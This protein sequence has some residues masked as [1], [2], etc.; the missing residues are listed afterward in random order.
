M[1]RP[2]PRHTRM[3]RE[4][5]TRIVALSLGISLTVAV[6]AR[7]QTSEDG[8]RILKAM[9]DYVA[10]QDS[11]YAT[12]D[13]DI[14][15]ITPQLQKIQF[16]SSGQLAMSRPDKIRVTR[17]GGY[18]DLELAFDGNTATVLERHTNNYAQ[19]KAPGSVDQLVDK[20]RD[21]LGTAVP[22]ADLILARAHSELVGDAFEIKYIGHAVIDG[23]ECDHLAFRGL[24]TDWQLWIE[25]GAKPIP[26]KYVI[27]SKTTAAAPQYTL[28][29]KDW[30]TDA[31]GSAE[32]FTF[33]TP[34]GA[35]LVDLKEL[36]EIDEVP[37]GQ[38]TGASQ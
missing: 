18:S 25:R 33:K 17:R 23:V 24:E 11:I 27:T 7:A 36:K 34:A 26:R 19:I 29:I 35:K 6:S 20:L 28:R 14:E 16:T 21:D 12:Y 22:G 30:A 5:A 31:P 8:P 4:L 38:T 13:S 9:T 1:N 15:V 10:S 3:N 2:G 37:P 32:A